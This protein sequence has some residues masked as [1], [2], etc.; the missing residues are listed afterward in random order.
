MDHTQIAFG[1]AKQDDGTPIQI[2]EHPVHNSIKCMVFDR[3]VI[4]FAATEL[5]KELAD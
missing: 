5:E 3:D 2:I 1:N 4:D